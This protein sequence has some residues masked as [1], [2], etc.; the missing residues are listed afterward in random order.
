MAGLIVPSFGFAKPP[1]FFLSCFYVFVKSQTIRLPPFAVVTY[2]F[3]EIFGSQESR[4]G[5]RRNVLCFRSGR[6]IVKI[7]GSD[8]N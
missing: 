1:N 6:E 4:K 5:L 8:L 2:T 3:F 7:L